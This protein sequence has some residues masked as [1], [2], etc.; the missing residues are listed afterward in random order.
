MDLQ[1]TFALISP[2]SLVQLLCQERRSVAITAWRGASVASLQIS[3]GLILA[4]RCDE[5]AGEAAVYRMM[6]WDSGRFVVEPIAAPTEAVFLANDWEGVLLEAARRR[7]ELEQQL[8]PL[9]PAPSRQQLD[10]LLAECPLLAGVALVGDDGRLFAAVNMDD[11]IVRAA[12]QIAVNLTL[13]GRLLD[14]QRE[15]VAVY[16]LANRR[17]LCCNTGDGMIVLATPTRGA[18]LAETAA[19]LHNWLVSDDVTIE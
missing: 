11:Q 12:P 14:G 13:I 2:A 10:A 1:G 7:D 5:L 3:E 4:A 6:V 15:Q 9:L 18:N 19:Q 16:A 17:L 8:A